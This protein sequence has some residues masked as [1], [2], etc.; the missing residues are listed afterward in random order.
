MTSFVNPKALAL[1]TWALLHKYFFF[2]TAAS[3]VLSRAIA[4]RNYW[5]SNAEATP[6]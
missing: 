5:S 3:L 2:I 1:E 4:R 6:K